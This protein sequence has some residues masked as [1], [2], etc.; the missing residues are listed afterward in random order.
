MPQT[1]FSKKKSCGHR[2]ETEETGKK[3]KTGLAFLAGFAG[4]AILAFLALLAYTRLTGG[5]A[6]GDFSNSIRGA[7]THWKLSRR[8]G[9]SQSH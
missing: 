3:G 9:I 4:L 8:A 6:H 5:I 7:H 2:D 1:I